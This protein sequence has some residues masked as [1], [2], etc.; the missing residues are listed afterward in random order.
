[1]R[2]MHYPNPLDLQGF[3]PHQIDKY[4]LTNIFCAVK[5]TS[6]FVNPNKTPEFAGIFGIC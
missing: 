5:D 4:C 6:N 3:L 2:K 1:M